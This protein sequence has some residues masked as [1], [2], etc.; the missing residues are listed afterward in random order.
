MQVCV[1]G[2]WAENVLILQSSLRNFAVDLLLYYRS[3]KFSLDKYSSYQFL[4]SLF[5]V[6]VDQ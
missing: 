3:G 1:F 6:A 4:Y 5:F 2:G